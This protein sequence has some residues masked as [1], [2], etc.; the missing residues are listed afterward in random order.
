MAKFS[1]LFS[2]SQVSID[3]N[4]SDDKTKSDDKVQRQGEKT[5]GRSIK[6]RKNYKSQE[7][8]N[9]RSGTESEEK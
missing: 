5:S 9:Y 2:P 1:I 4:S 7:R 6:E 3:V 8:N